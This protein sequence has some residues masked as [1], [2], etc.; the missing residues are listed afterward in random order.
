[1]NDPTDFS[2]LKVGSINTNSVQTSTLELQNAGPITWPGRGSIVNTA[3]GEWEL[4]DQSG[5]PA[6]GTL[7]AA[8]IDWDPPMNEIQ[9]MDRIGVCPVPITLRWIPI[10][11]KLVYLEIEGTSFTADADGPIIIGTISPPFNRFR[12]QN[13]PLPYVGGHRGCWVGQLFGNVLTITPDTNRWSV[14]ISGQS[15]TW[16]TTGVIVSLS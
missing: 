1:M 8:M 7:R 3:D 5:A 4:R 16:L 15:Y 13:F 14:F 10:N 2:L 6:S 12:L 9:L 11:N